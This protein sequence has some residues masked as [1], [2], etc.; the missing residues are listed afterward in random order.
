LGQ[1]ESEFR[2]PQTP[3]AAD[4]R[5]VNAAHAREAI[6][7]EEV[8][9]SKP[10]LSKLETIDV[11]LQPLL[12]AAAKGE[13]LEPALLEITR[14]LGFESFVYGIATAQRP[15]RDSHTYVWTSLPKEWLTAYEQNA[16]IEVDP[17]VTAGLDRASPFVWDA[18][19]IEGDVRVRRFLD[20]AA[21]YGICS[22]VVIAFS[23]PSGSRVGFGLN[24]SISPLS[25]ERREEISRQLGT[26]MVLGTRLHD[27]FVAQI[28]Q[29][30]APPAHTG[31][32]L[33]PREKQ[34][35]VMAARG[36]T[37]AD[38]GIKLGI[39]NRTANFH[40]GNV[41]TKL[42]VLNRNEAIAKAITLG[43]INVKT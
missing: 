2:C 32:R 25:A 28:I 36:L 10:D 31:K 20:H 22:G 19:S 14:S 39:T 4:H 18:A 38:I 41:L 21:Q 33:S 30:G 13:P 1:N 40:F 16:Y 27:L 34:C 15:N 3:W 37:S 29:G 23:T 35:L 7:L 12:N 5:I 6:M 11:L 42:G 26:L 8:R 17:R 24:S 9:P 43:L